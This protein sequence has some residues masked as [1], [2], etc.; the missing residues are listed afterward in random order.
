VHP[1][2]AKSVARR[3]AQHSD[4]CLLTLA[5]A[6]AFRYGLSPNKLFDYL[7][8]AK[9][10]LISAAQPTLVDE[11]NAGIRYQPGDPLALAKAITEI[12]DRPAAE[13]QARGDRGRKVVE[14]AFS[15][16]SVTDRYEDLLGELVKRNESRTRQPARS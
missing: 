11:A 16:E 14:G 7:A 13:R 5:S 12:M 6:D 9:P 4:A 8:V 2:V 10:V 15:V 1:A 3:L